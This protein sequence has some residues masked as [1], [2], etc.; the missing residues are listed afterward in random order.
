MHGFCR[1]SPATSGMR[2]R[3]S[4]QDPLQHVASSARIVLSSP[5]SIRE[6]S[7]VPPA[8][9]PRRRSCAHMVV[10]ELLAETQPEYRERRLEAEE[11][12]RQTIDSGQAMRVVSKLITIP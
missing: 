7:A 1:R 2:I 11:Q 5:T 9:K 6:E 8:K 10:H 3:P 12:T 4:A